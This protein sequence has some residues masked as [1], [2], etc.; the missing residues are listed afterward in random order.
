MELFNINYSIKNEKLLLFFFDF[1][2]IYT[3]IYKLLRTLVTGYKD[4]H[5]T[6]LILVEQSS[7]YVLQ[8]NYLTS[9]T[10][11]KMENYLENYFYFFPL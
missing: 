10:Q 1:N 9:T 6:P 4:L 3:Q 7:L 11:S 8:W 2:N 5:I